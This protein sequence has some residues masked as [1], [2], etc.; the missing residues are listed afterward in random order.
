MTPLSP[1]ASSDPSPGDGADASLRYRDDAS[2]GAAGNGS[3]RAAQDGSSLEY[4]CD[5]SLTPRGYGSL[6]AV[7]DAS[8]SPAVDASPTP[9]CCAWC[10]SPLEQTARPYTLYCSKKC[11]QT[12]WRFRQQA[13][14]V[15]VG[16]TPKRLGY[17]D[18]PYP[19]MARRYYGKEPTYAGEV[20]HAELVARLVTYDGWALSTSEKTLREVLPLCPKGV[21]VAVWAK[22]HGAPSTTSGPHNCWEPI[23][24]WPARRVRPGFP[25]WLKALP[26]RGGGTLPGRKPIAFCA[27]VFRL[28]GAAPI[29]SLDDIYPG[30][31]IV[32]RA[33][34]EL[35]RRTSATGREP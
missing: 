17:A 29:D 27:F 19:G 32:G 28:I 12:A 35:S 25:D 13:V 6:G 4:S 23:I 9:G 8:P 30:T 21:R 10:R 15:A 1:E 7:L 11:R 5:A 2:S 33:F 18:P 31:G 20:D 24:Y 3:P 34:A 14:A 22:P 16:K 26:A